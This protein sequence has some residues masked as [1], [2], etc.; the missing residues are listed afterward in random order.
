MRVGQVGNI[1]KG[2]PVLAPPTPCVLVERSGSGQTIGNGFNS[3]SSRL[4]DLRPNV[5]RTWWS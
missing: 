2:E 3:V 5:G 1:A 4:F